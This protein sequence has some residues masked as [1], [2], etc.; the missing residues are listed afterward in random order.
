MA[1][2][3]VTAHEDRLRTAQVWRDPTGPSVQLI[4][5]DKIDPGRTIEGTSATE[6][7][8]GVVAT[9]AWNPNDFDAFVLVQDPQWASYLIAASVAYNSPEQERVSRSVGLLERYSSHTP[10]P[11]SFGEPLCFWTVVAPNENEA[12]ALVSKAIGLGSV[13]VRPG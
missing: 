4:T 3:H 10:N 7:L 2:T 6:G 9:G 11:N 5:I 12:I 8:A 1:P 13:D